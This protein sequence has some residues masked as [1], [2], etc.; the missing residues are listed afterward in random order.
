MTKGL[1]H[2]T[3]NELAERLRR[4]EIIETSEKFVI[5]SA[6][7]ESLKEFASLRTADD[8]HVVCNRF[9]DVS[10]LDEDFVLQSLSLDRLESAI[11]EVQRLRK[12]GRTFSVTVSKF[13]ND[14][15]DT[16]S[17]QSKIASLVVK[18]TSRE[19]TPRDHTNLDVR[20]HVESSSF[21]YSCR[22]PRFSLYNRSYRT[23]EM[24][25][26]LRP[27]IAA[28][29]CRLADSRKGAR[30]VDNF[31]G[32]GT[33]LCEAISVGL[34][35][36]GGDISEES[37][38]CAQ[39]NL[40]NISAYAA[41]RVRV[42]DARSTKWPSKY[43]DCAISNY[44]WGKQSALDKVVDL[45]SKSIEEYARILK[46]RGTLVLLGVNPE[47]M[48]KHLRKNFP[49]HEISQTRIGFLGETPWIS[50][51]SPMALI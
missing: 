47:L 23:C 34:E 7:D 29:L 8:V 14:L 24:E 37:V 5:F 43:F 39:Q 32:T 6:Q 35:P 33:I 46:D 51:V 20:V 44:P 3:E 10:Q 9:R 2:I 22:L 1:K 4:P 21:F 12:V 40:R 50:V 25:G 19:Y 30:I 13:K 49:S 31:C 45:Y 28:S 17:L 26:S 15:I 41:E 42:L 38:S 16:E 36:Y 27:P 18:W 48:A 11:H